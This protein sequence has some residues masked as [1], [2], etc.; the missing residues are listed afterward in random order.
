MKGLKMIYALFA[1][2]LLMLSASALAKEGKGSSGKS[3]G[4]TPDSPLWGIDTAFENIDLALTFD[5]EVKV[6]KRLEIARERL[7]EAQ[8]MA[9]RSN[10]DAVERAQRIHERQLAAVRNTL[11]LLEGVNATQELRANVEFEQELERQNREATKLEIRVRGNL[12]QEQVDKLLALFESFKNESDEARLEVRQERDRIRIKLRTMDALTEDEVRDIEDEIEVEARINATNLSQE[13]VATQFVRISERF[14]SL[15]ENRVNMTE[16]STAK[17][18]ARARL[19]SAVSLQAQAQAALDAGNFADA[20]RLALEARR[21]ARRALVIIAGNFEER[22]EEEFEVEIEQRLGEDRLKIKTKVEIED[23][24]EDEIEE[25][26]IEIEIGDRRRHRGSSSSGS[27][28][29]GSGSDSSGRSGSSGGGSSG[30]SGSGSGRSG[31][32]D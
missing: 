22:I 17:A 20:R 8:L 11:R 16:N 26:E 32:E 3:A 13:V 18:E 19:D 4:I 30:G 5:N 23:E 21:E 28:S 29:S 9:E 12:S 15:V 31:S 10:V 6:R 2:M 24:I 27:D 14:I 1:V 25:D 7:L